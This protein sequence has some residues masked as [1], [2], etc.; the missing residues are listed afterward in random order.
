MSK[1]EEAVLV[2]LF[3]GIIF[4]KNA[5]VYE[6]I[7]RLEKR[8][9]KTDFISEILPFQYTT[10]YEKEMGSELSRTVITFKPLIKRD[11]LVKIKHFT[12]ELEKSFSTNGNRQINLDPGYIAPEHLI[13]ATGKGYYHRPYLGQGVYADLT[14]VFKKKDFRPLR[15]TYPDYRTTKLRRIFKNLREMYMAELAE[16]RLA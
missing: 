16:T 1:L 11:K 5:Q 12:N 4:S 15:W 14:L 9:G 3:I 6:C 2:K 7:K 10:Y 8:L 13:L